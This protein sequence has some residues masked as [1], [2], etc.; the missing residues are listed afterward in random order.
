MY[1][2]Y[3]LHLNNSSFYTGYTINIIKR[4]KEH[5]NGRVKSTKNFRPIKL[6]WYCIFPSRLQARR[7]ENYLKTGSGQAFR[8]KRLIKIN[9]MESWQSGRMRRS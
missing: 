3:I 2:V 4:L 6:V 1:Y 5:K 7:F 8:N 9:F